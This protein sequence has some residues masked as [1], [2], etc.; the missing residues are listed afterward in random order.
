MSEVVEALVRKLSLRQG[1]A[2]QLLTLL[3][4]IGVPSEVV[5]RAPCPSMHSRQ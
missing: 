3:L 4:S 1:F 2:E 5:K